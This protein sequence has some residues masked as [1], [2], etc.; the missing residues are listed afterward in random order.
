[1]MAFGVLLL[2]ENHQC[3]T[4]ISNQ[5]NKRVSH[6]E[7]PSRLMASNY[8]GSS[9]QRKYVLRATLRATVMN[10]RWRARHTRGSAAE[11]Q[12]DSTR[13]HRSADSNQTYFVLQK[14][15]GSGVRRWRYRN[16]AGGNEK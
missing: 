14:T 4:V 2:H 16:D 15:M 7:L 3:R 9:G 10:E 6:L 13:C 5:K 12:Q 1:M 8:A 11:L